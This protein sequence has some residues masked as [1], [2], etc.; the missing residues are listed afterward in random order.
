MNPRGTKK[1]NQKKWL[2]LVVVVAAVI[3]LFVYS[4]SLKNHFKPVDVL[5]VSYVAKDKSEGYEVRFK[6]QKDRSYEI[7]RKEK[8]AYKYRSCGIVKATDKTT[9]FLD[10][11]IQP[12]ASYRYGARQVT[13]KGEKVIATGKTGKK[14]DTPEGLTEGTVTPGNLATEVS[15]SHVGADAYEIYRKLPGET[16]FRKIA[17]VADTDLGSKEKGDTITYEDKYEETFTQKEKNAYLDGKYVVYLDP[18]VNG[19]RY[20]IVPV[21]EGDYTV[22]GAYKK[23]GYFYL[24]KATLVK[25]SMKDE[26]GTVP[27]A[28]LKERT[29]TEVVLTWHA[30]P[31]VDGYVVRQGKE[32]TLGHAVKWTD[33]LDTGNPKEKKAFSYKEETTGSNGCSLSDESVTSASVTLPY[34]KDLPYYTVVAYYEDN[35]TRVYADYEEDFTV[36]NRTYSN[37]SM[38]YIADSIA[39]GTPYTTTETGYEYSFPF[40]VTQLTALD[41]YNAGIPGATVA[42]KSGLSVR[43]YLSDELYRLQEGKTPTCYHLLNMKENHR[44]LADFDIIVLEGGANDHTWDID[45]GAEDSREKDTFYGAWNTI[46]DAIIEASREREQSGKDPIK[47]VMMDLFYSDKDNEQVT[48]PVSREDAKNA[49]GLTYKDYQK[50][51]NSLVKRYQKEPDIEVFHFVNEDYHFVTRE[52][53]NRTTVDNL[54]LTAETAV[55]VGT[56]FAQFL[57]D[58]L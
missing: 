41:T 15:F 39:Y 58:I 8:G 46:F 1:N 37:V 9:A 29:P 38:L 49:Y 11:E 35:G 16:E 26:K 6:T 33:I 28:E 32:K 21:Y 52:N 18:C 25:A 43:N 34:N 44:A 45:L 13:V 50:A 42:Q 22:Y 30:V 53:C 47:V 19:N 24:Q 20:R 12:D 17:T 2:I 40:R 5:S 57:Q 3:G 14:G 48:I 10:E 23:E 31:N 36:E 51:I 55:D 56:R 54:H 7:I 27:S 4:P